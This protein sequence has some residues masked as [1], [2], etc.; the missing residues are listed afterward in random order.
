MHLHQ[1]LH[2]RS[3][4]LTHRSHVFDRLFLNLTADEATPGT[5]NRVELEGGEAH[6]DDLRR[7]F[8]YRFRCLGPSGPSVG[9]DPYLVP[10]GPA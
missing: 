9:V 1:N 6:L 4:G 3:H 5:G 2:V 7:L 10:A 8:C